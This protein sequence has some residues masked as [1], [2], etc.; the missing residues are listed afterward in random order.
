M[1]PS[2]LKT[3]QLCQYRGMSGMIIANMYQEWIRND[4]EDS[5]DHTRLNVNKANVHESIEAVVRDTGIAFVIYGKGENI[6]ADELFHVALLISREKHGVEYVDCMA[7]PFNQSQFIFENKCAEICRRYGK[8]FVGSDELFSYS[9]SEQE[10]TYFPPQTAEQQFVGMFHKYP[11]YFFEDIKDFDA[12]EQQRMVRFAEKYSYHDG[13]DCI[14]WAFHIAI[15]LTK[16]DISAQEWFERQTWFKKHNELQAGAEILQY[17][18]NKI[19]ASLLRCQK[20]KLKQ[21]VMQ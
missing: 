4:C 16:L 10:Y 12:A 1:W 18:T 6:P 5:L 13:G 2:Q 20:S 14:F 19:F 9:E 15:Q 11:E 3:Q 17:V 8:P 7:N 21:V